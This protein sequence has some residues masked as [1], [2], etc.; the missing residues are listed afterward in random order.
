MDIPEF[1]EKC[2]ELIGSVAVSG[3]KVLSV[4]KRYNLYENEAEFFISVRFNDD[5]KPN[6][7]VS[8]SK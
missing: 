6:H 1:L 5:I 4:E 7:T 2:N 3:C 8:D